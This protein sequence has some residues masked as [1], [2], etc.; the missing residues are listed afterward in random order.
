MS[1]FG[2]FIKIVIFNIFLSI[3]LSFS[4]AGMIARITARHITT[5]TVNLK[6]RRQNCSGAEMFNICSGAYISI[7]FQLFSYLKTARLI[8]ILGLKYLCINQRVTSS[9]LFIHE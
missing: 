7:I 8:H 2:S 5:E 1:N 4:S 3:I 6:D 9:N